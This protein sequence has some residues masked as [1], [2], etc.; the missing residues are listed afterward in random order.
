VAERLE[1]ERRYHADPE[2]KVFI[3]TIQSCAEALTL[4]PTGTA[5]ITTSYVYNPSTL[6]QAE[7]RI[8]RLNQTNDVDIIYLH[9]QVPGGS[10]DDRFVEILDTK[11][12]LISQVVDRREHVDVTQTHYSTNDLVWL[13]TG[14]RDE[15][16][17]K[18]EADKK[19]AVARE[20]A[21]KQH[22]KATAHK[23]K[24]KNDASVFRDDGS[25]AVVLDD[26]AVVRHVKPVD[27]VAFDDGGPDDTP[28]AGP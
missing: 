4:S 6:S 11:R 27:D 28:T 12:A 14:K 21:K 24:Y 20:Q 26:E 5:W 2:V 17:E 18:L 1:S 23:R 19:A 3:G 22:A 8:Y 13:L 10:L 7:A 15:R 25:V 9:A 16:L